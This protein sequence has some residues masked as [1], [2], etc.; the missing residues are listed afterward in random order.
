MAMGIGRMLGFH[1]PNNF[2]HPYM[3]GSV[4]EFWRRWHITLGKWLKDYVY[5]PLGGN[6][7]GKA[8]LAFN[9]LLVWLFTGLW[10][11]A[12]WNFVLWGLTLFALILFLL[13]S[14]RAKVVCE[15]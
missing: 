2:N 14:L 13:F 4:T 6:R 1:L 5:I 7:K 10:H 8:R 9:L 3:A 15:I 12:G 11:G